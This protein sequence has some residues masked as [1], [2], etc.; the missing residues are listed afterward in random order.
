MSFSARLVGLGTLALC[1]V[2]ATCK[3]PAP[4]ETL[5][6]AGSSAMKLYMAPVVEAFAA[7]N[8]KASI[9]CEEGGAAAG[10][11]ALKR[12]AI[13]V[14]MIGRDVTPEE[15]ED[16]LRDF[17]VARD[18]VAIVVP[19]A[20]PIS[21]LTL[22]QLAEIAS[23][24]VTSWKAIGGADAPITVLDRPVTSELRKSFMDLVLEGEEPTH[25]A[26]I[27]K[28]NEEL[29]ATLAANP[30]AIGYVSYHHADSP[31]IKTLTIGG[32]EMNRGTMLSGRYPLTRSFYLAVYMK[33]TPLADAFI[34][35]AVSKEGQS[36]LAGKGLLSVY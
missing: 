11:I 14:A 19:K 6:I 9:V 31:G 23:G 32:V 34:S 2:G 16:A 13:D 22:K 4:Q 1:L 8:P 18:G 29:M 15:D 36:L 26:T 7:K 27:A 20:N 30:H 5:L 28:G 21:S 33:P 25:A 17:L 24:A 35:F 3:A 10:V 12:E